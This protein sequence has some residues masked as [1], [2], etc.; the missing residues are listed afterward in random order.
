MKMEGVDCELAFMP[1]EIMRDLCN[2]GVK[3][4]EDNFYSAIQVIRH[5]GLPACKV[6]RE[7]V[8]PNHSEY[9]EINY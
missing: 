4:E 7:T 2:L 3:F 5:A 1:R 8:H 9:L 6:Y